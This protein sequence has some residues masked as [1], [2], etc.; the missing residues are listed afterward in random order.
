MSLPVKVR[1]RQLHMRMNVFILAGMF[2]LI[3]MCP[4]MTV[5]ASYTFM[6]HLKAPLSALFRH[7]EPSAPSPGIWM[8]RLENIKF[9]SSSGIRM[10]TSSWIAASWHLQQNALFRLRLSLLSLRL[11]VAMAETRVWLD[12]HAG[13]DKRAECFFELGSLWGRHLLV[14]TNLRLALWVWWVGG[15]GNGGGGGVWR[16]GNGLRV[17]TMEIFLGGE[18][19]GRVEPEVDW[20]VDFL[21]GRR[22]IGGCLGLNWFIGDISC[23]FHFQCILHPVID[24]NPAWLFSV[25][26]NLHSLCH[27]FKD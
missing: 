17:M 10:H 19:V 12:V 15:R 23:S 22:M 24:P 4:V 18:Q 21:Y 1:Q 8:E 11:F 9:L 26:T 6:C 25:K 7:F 27:P 13:S 20:A 3:F 5:M 2:I 16:N 14:L